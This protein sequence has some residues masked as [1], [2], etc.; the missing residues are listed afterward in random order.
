MLLISSVT[1]ASNHITLLAVSET[2]TGFA[3]STA[4]LVLEIK[5]GTGHVFIDSF[6]L[7]KIDTQV[8]TRFAKEIACSYLEIDCRAYDFF[9]TMRASSAIVG[10]ASA[11]AATTVLTVA[12]LQG[13][14]LPQDIAMTG[15]INSGNLI[16]SVSGLKEKIEAAA[17][18]EISVVLLP[19][20]QLI[21]KTKIK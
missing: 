5:P 1:A 4:D 11:G 21:Y 19:K 2:E 17:Q 15:T 13:I 7:T 9:Y 12:T 20:T 10:G 6:P 3:G 8:T 18:K 14:T 16:G